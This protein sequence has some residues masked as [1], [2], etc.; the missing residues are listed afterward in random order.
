MY[1][2]PIKFITEK[3]FCIMLDRYR[4][5]KFKLTDNNKKQICF[6]KEYEGYIL[7]NVDK[8]DNITSNFK[9][10]ETIEQYLLNDKFL[11]DK[12]ILDKIIIDIIYQVYKEDAAEDLIEYYTTD[13]FI[14]TEELVAMD[15]IKK[16]DITLVDKNTNAI[17]LYARNEYTVVLQNNNGELFIFEINEDM[18]I[19]FLVIPAYLKYTED[20]YIRN[21]HNKY[22]SIDLNNNYEAVI[23]Y[24]LSNE[25]F[26]IQNKINKSDK[27]VYTRGDAADVIMNNNILCEFYEDIERVKDGSIIYYNT[28]EDLVDRIIEVAKDKDIIEMKTGKILATDDYLH[29]MAPSEGNK[30]LLARD[31]SNTL[32]YLEVENTEEPTIETVF[33]ETYNC[34]DYSKVII[35]TKETIKAFDDFYNKFLRD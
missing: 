8:D 24:N 19:R 34:D 27:T 18:A 14:E 10:T 22:V 35:G 30:Y 3:E 4:H 29:H 5:L 1:N 12:D 13:R 11:P 32:Y 15:G 6:T 2:F 31:T 28:A 16:G 7:Y 9:I 23:K 21:Y 33:I 26:T 20:S 25:L 17:Y